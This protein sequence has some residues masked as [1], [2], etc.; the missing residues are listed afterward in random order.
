MRLEQLK[1][2]ESSAVEHIENHCCPDNCTERAEGTHVL[3]ISNKLP[4][5]GKNL[6]CAVGLVRENAAFLTR[7]ARKA[8][9]GVPRRDIFFVVVCIDERSSVA[10][11]NRASAALTSAIRRQ[12][13]RGEVTCLC[14]S[15]V[16]TLLCAERDLLSS[17]FI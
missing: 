7:P 13:S 11:A 2:F 4:Q 10:S 14:D 16:N 17:R 9:A 6:H 5:T 3:Y 8:T 12:F 15:F 1:T